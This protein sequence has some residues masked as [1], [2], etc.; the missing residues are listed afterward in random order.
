MKGNS[1]LNS[2]YCTQCGNQGIPIW[3]KKNASRE[4]GHL[5]KIFCLNCQKETNHVECNNNYTYEDFIFEFKHKNFS[6]DGQRL[7]TYKQ[8]RSVIEN[9]ENVSD[10]GDSGVR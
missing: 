8:L 4:K 5:K 1:I 6:A 9:E 10:G 3:R 2:F 7:M